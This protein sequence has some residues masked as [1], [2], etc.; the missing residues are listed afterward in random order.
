MSHEKQKRDE[1]APSPGEKPPAEPPGR[2]A[3]RASRRE[4]TSEPSGIVD[5]LAQLR[6][7]LFGAA[8]RDLERRLERAD[9]H[10][11]ARAHELEQESRRRTEVIEAHIR[12]ETE[13]L[14]ASME[15]ELAE[16]SETLRAIT[17]EHRESLTALEQR[18]A[19]LEEQASRAQR[20]LRQQLLEQAKGFL[21]EIQR[22]RHEFTDALER[23]LGLTGRAQEEEEVGA[24]E[25]R[26]A[27]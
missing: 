9:V 11:A 22:L 18:V 12:R 2:P 25:R 7:I 24:E 8:Q 5:S 6:E 1:L 26:P 21:D 15:R 16:R 3:N 14:T 23:E 17:R 4:G 10:L 27:P 20:E 13:A 19:K